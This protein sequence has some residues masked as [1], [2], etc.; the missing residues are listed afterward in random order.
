MLIL[1]IRYRKKKGVNTNKQAQNHQQSNKHNRQ[2]QKR[3]ARQLARDFDSA[4]ADYEGSQQNSIPPRQQQSYADLI[5]DY[6]SSNSRATTRPSYNQQYQQQPSFHNNAPTYGQQQPS[7]VQPQQIYQQ[8]QQAYQQPQQG[9]QS[10]QSPADLV[11]ALFQ[12]YGGQLPTNLRGPNST[13]QS[14]STANSA[15]ATEGPYS[16]F[17]EPPPPLSELEKQGKK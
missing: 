5:D 4:L 2:Q 17:S 10:Y 6:S 1:C 11:S 7:G 8:P 15:T 13:S 16:M 3:P 14:D 12:S 9:Q